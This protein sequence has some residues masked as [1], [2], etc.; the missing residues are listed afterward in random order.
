MKTFLNNVRKALRPERR[1]RRGSRPETFRPAVEPL[2]T[3]LV[4]SLVPASSPIDVTTGVGGQRLTTQRTVAEA[5]NGEYRVVWEDTS[6]GIFTRLFHGDGTPL[7]NPVQVPGTGVAD[8]E[9]TVAMD[10]S[11]ASVIAWT[12]KI[13]STN[14][15][16]L[17]RYNP[18]GVSVGAPLIVTSAFPGGSA[19]V[20]RGDGQRRRHR[21]GLHRQRPG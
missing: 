15:V 20:E 7:A 5:G 9:A 17:Q 6:L 13:G 16:L 21:P 11:R 2:E 18:A 4:P 8:S 19:P 3:R 12:H 14:S 1:R 10:A